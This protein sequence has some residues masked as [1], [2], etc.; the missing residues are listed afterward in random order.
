MAATPKKTKLEPDY[1]ADLIPAPRSSSKAPKET[2]ASSR[3]SVRNTYEAPSS[4]SSRSASS[5][6]SHEPEERY[7]RSS[8]PAPASPEPDEYVWE[9][10]SEDPAT[11]RRAAQRRADQSLDRQ[12]SQAVGVGAFG[13]PPDAT[14][15]DRELWAI[16]RPL[17]A[18]RSAAVVAVDTE[19]VLVG[20]RQPL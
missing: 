3:S 12:L 18:A 1:F 8:S 4:T 9:E 5:R 16:C 2:D 15:L 20:H 14:P 6:S 19:L 7:G 13:P 10:T 11:R 17:A